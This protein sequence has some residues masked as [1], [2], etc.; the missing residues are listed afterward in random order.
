MDIRLKSVDFDYGGKTYKLVCNMNVLADVQEYNNGALASALNNSRSLKNTLQ[1]LAA[2]MNDCAETYG[3]S[4]RFT[5]VQL[6]RELNFKEVLS[7]G[8]K[9]F[10]IIND[11]LKVMEETDKEENDEKK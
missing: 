10:P 7:A 4:E 1:F 9:I 3:Y 8:K 6:G 5:P 2:M 11:A